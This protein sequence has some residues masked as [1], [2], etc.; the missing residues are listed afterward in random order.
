MVLYDPHVNLYVRATQVV[1]PVAV[2]PQEAALQE[3][4]RVRNL[5]LYTLDQMEDLLNELDQCV[6]GWVGAHPPGG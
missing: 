2:P 3:L 6:A 5:G 1:D 4:R